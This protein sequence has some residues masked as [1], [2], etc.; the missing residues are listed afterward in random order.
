MDSLARQ[1]KQALYDT[2]FFGYASTMDLQSILKTASVILTRLLQDQL[3]ELLTVSR[4]P[5]PNNV[6]D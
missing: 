4:N 5:S 6:C 3:E 2:T 1:Q